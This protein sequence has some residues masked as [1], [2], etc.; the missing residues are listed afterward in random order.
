[1]LAA[2]DVAGYLLDRR[3]LSPRAVVHGGLRVTDTSRLN[4]VFVVTTEDGPCFVLKAADGADGAGVA[5][6]AAVL[7]R[8]AAVD[9]LARWLPRLVVHDHAGGLIVFESARHARDLTR[10]HARGRFSC[11]LARDAGR[12]LALL[13]ALGPAVLDVEPTD[14]RPALRLHEPDLESIRGMSPAAIELTRI[15]QG[16]HELCAALDE[17]AATWRYDA[18]IHGDIRWDNLV[19]VRRDASTRWTRLQLIDWELCGPGDPAFDIGAYLGEYL[20]AWLQSIPITDPEDPA[21]LLAHAGLPLR[22]M[23]PVLR[24][25]WSAYADHARATAPELSRRLRRASR[26]AG[27]RLL[28]AALEEAQG[29]DELRARVAYLVPLSRNVLRRPEEASAYLL[30]LSG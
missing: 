6:E 21:R 30:G 5:R 26:F 17:L 2:A 29:H 15:I 20:R 13:H 11:A 8:L 12:A 7:E 27:L 23:R 10:H 14:P 22:R 28:T 25:F 16:S 9:G 1:V 24:A 19:A 4:R 3:L 18:V